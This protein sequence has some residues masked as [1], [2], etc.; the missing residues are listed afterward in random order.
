MLFRS[1]V[2]SIGTNWFTAV[3]GAA[4]T[5]PPTVATTVPADA[6]IAVA[7][8]ANVVWN[9]SEAILLSDVNATNFFVYADA[10]NSVVAGA[11]SVNAAH[12]QVTF[13][14]TA[15][16][17]AASKYWAAATGVRDMAGNAM[18]APKMVSFTTA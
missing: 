18:A 4:D 15:N 12:T 17:T 16:L 1:Y 8:T 10:D 13:D 9:F 2:A 14:P 11:L 5:T 6:A 3:E 7:I